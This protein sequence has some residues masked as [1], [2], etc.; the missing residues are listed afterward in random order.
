MSTLFPPQHWLKL[1]PSL[2]HHL[3]QLKYVGALSMKG[4]VMDTF[5]KQSALN[6]LVCL[7]EIQTPSFPDWVT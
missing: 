4:Y 5:F 7:D 6:P 1:Q 3:A 2:D